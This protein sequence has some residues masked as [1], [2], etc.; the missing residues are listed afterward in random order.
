MSYYKKIDGKSIYLAS[1]NLDDAESY[2]QM[3]N[4]TDISGQIVFDQYKTD[5]TYDLEKAREELNNLAVANA[6][7]IVS[8]DTNKMIGLIGLSNTL[9]LNQRSDMWIKMYTNIDI[10]RQI[11]QGGE[12]VDLLL[13]YCYNV[14]N[15]HSVVMTTPIFNMQAIHILSNSCMEYFGTRTSSEKFSDGKYYDMAYYQC[16]PEI[17][18][19]NKNMKSVLRKSPIITSGKTLDTLNFD[20]SN[21]PNIISGDRIT[22][23]KYEGEQE[24]I[25]QLATYLND[26]RV[27][28]PL[29]EYKTNWNNYRAE[30]QLKNVNY[31]ITKGDKLLG[32]LD[33]FRQ[34]FRNKTSD[35]AILIGDVSEQGKGYGKEA[36]ELFL[37]EQYKNGAF[38]NILSCIFEFNKP[39][40]GL[41]N[42]I[43]YNPIGIRKEGYFANGKLNDMHL[44]EMTEEIYK[45]KIK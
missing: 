27:S 3:K 19:I 26:S 4:A 8:K 22:L 34:D 12:A 1:I 29:G 14:M 41:H 6:F 39:S 32:Y 16:T 18:K 23:S 40:L 2:L 30:K 9:A 21:M 31:I 44:Y 35:L 45:Q 24:Y 7:A 28:I 17:Y 43:G 15:L 5:E 20:M 11:L 13:D 37:Q 36:L 42:S 25:G 33:L 38:N 10:E